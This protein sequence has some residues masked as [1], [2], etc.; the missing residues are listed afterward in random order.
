MS[1]SLPVYRFSRTSMNWYVSIYGYIVS[2]QFI[3]SSKN[4]LKWCG[5]F[6]DSRSRKI[7]TKLP[8]VQF[9]FQIL[10]IKKTLPIQT[11]TCRL[12]SAKWSRRVLWIS[13]PTVGLRW[14]KILDLNVVLMPGSA[15]QAELLITSQVSQL[16]A[17]GL[18][19]LLYAQPKLRV[20]VWNLPLLNR[21]HFLIDLP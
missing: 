7:N 5:Q 16:T 1:N 10:Y 4:N 15:R 6:T 19:Y 14:I 12:R 8:A 2:V 18:L 17:C 11:L 13:N 20:R 3:F 21:Q 9:G